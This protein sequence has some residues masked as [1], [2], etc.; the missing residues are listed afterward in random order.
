MTPQQA[1]TVLSTWLANYPTIPSAMVSPELLNLV[2]ELPPEPDRLELY[3]TLLAIAP[4]H[5]GLHRRYAQTLALQDPTAAIAYL[6]TLTSDDPTE[7]APYFVQGEVAQ[8]LNELELASQAYETVLQS[9]PDNVAALSALGG[10]RFQQWRLEEAERL[11][12]EILTLQ[13]QDW[14]TQ[15][16]LAE[17]HMAQDNS[18]AAIE[19]FRQLEHANQTSSV[20]PPIDL[21]LQEIRLNLLRRRGFQPYWE[22]Y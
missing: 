13:P 5:I 21:R 4:T 11:Y 9:E 1:E 22:Q 15:R 8:T 7:I 6:A 17:L 16:I 10:V 14:E 19:Q 12:E 2:G 18:I 20:G 3:E